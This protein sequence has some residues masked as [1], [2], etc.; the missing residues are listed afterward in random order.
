MSMNQVL[1]G[2]DEEFFKAHA[3]LMHSSDPA[4]LDQAASVAVEIALKLGDRLM[5]AC[6]FGRLGDFASEGRYMPPAL[7]RGVVAAYDRYGL[8]L[9][10]RGPGKPVESGQREWARTNA[11]LV[12]HYYSRC[13][14][15][16]AAAE[17]ASEFRRGG[18]SPSQ[19]KR[20]FRAARK[21]TK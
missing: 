10:R 19:M 21:P 13:G 12:E 8:N 7:V 16:D 4:A 6:L 1:A 14:N 2:L 5:L 20:D 3:V 17:M 11:R 18:V 9:K 15:L